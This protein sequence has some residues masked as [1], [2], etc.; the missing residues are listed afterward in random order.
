[1]PSSDTQFGKGQS[2]NP[3]GRP[4][5]KPWADAFRKFG[6]LPVKELASKDGDTAIEAVVKK[7][8]IAMLK[9]PM[10]RLI[11]EAADRTEGRVPLPLIGSTD[12][13]IAIVIQSHIPRPDRSKKAIHKPA[14]KPN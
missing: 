3:G 11:R 13:P 10:A 8:Y 12:E 1:M 2:G 6:K 9:D 5:D 7:A 14:K 4:K